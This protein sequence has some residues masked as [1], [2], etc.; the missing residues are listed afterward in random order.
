M[1]SLLRRLLFLLPPETSHELSLRL[2]D[3]VAASPA[4]VFISP[5][6]AVL[7]AQQGATVLGLRFPNR[8]GLAAGL[9]KNGDHFNALAA[10]GFGS[11]EI[12]TVTPRP[13]DGNPKPRLFRIPS[14]EAIINRMGFNNKGV[15]HLVEKALQ[16]NFNGVLGINIG[17]NLTTSVESALDDYLVAFRQCYQAADYITVNISSPN[18]PG[19]RALQHG[20]LLSALIA[21]LREEQHQLEAAHGK[22][23]PIFFKVAPDLDDDEIADISRAFVKEGVEG[24]IATN[25]TSGRL[26]V[27]NDPVA[28][29]AGGLSGRPVF[30][31]S[32]RALRGFRAELPETMPIIAAGGVLSADDAQVKIDAGAA[33]VQI[34]SGFIYKGPR[35][36]HDCIKKIG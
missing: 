29:E 14:A 1:Y 9:D 20:D 19:L 22:H 32:T 30:E 16:R 17:K 36:I 12:G 24:V 34:Y 33:L 11:L 35:L 2:L 13:Q 10:V 4:R 21:G 28:G 27:E 7:N 5:P 18:T 23:V 25:T 15:D 26:G 8:V 31:I 3:A 6:K